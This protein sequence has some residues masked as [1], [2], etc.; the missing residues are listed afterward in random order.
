MAAWVLPLLTLFNVLHEAWTSAIGTLA[1]WL[2]MVA[3]DL[4][5][6]GAQR[7]PAPAGPNEPLRFL[8]RG[9]VVVQLL[10]I[11]CGAWA[12]SQASWPVVLGLAFSVGF[13][14][15]GQGITYAHELGHS[16]RRSDRA[17]A[18]VLMATVFYPQFMV[19]HYRGHHPRAATHDDPAS[20]RRGESLWR[21]LPRTLGGSFM[22]AWRLEAARLQQRGRGW[23]H[24]PL[25]WSF[26][27]NL[28]AA[29]ACWAVG[30]PKIA[31]FYLLQSVVAILLLETVN[32][33]EHYGLTRRVDAAGKRE[34]FGVMHAWNADHWLSNAVLANLQRHSDHH[35]H[36]WK[37]YPELEALP[38]PQLPTGYPGC[39]FLAALPPV[40]FRLMH[41]RIDAM[42]A[43]A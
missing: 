18:W 10:L 1:V 12:A 19:E 34:A 31:A 29:P 2:L 35:M 8:L 3:V 25:A 9:Y 43:P 28:V 22:G 32:Y 13:I 7:S 15:G 6:P 27:L 14:T 41:R 42:P 17:L 26:G 20:A 11:G 37:P 38:G 40:W 36:A 33:I 39:L 16:K 4:F 30:A 24:S 21:F 5:W 23:L